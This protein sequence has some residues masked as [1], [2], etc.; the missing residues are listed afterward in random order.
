MES[1]T[2]TKNN[3]SVAI[4]SNA[5]NHHQF[6][7]CDS[8][9]KEDGVIFNFIATKPIAKERL[10]IG[11]LDL[12]NSREYIIRPYESEQ[13]KKRALEIAKSCDFVIYGSAPFEYIKDRIKNKKWTFIYSER[14]FKETRA[15]DLF[16][17]KTILACILRYSFVSH[18]KIRLLCSSAF[19][20]NDF[21][22]FGFKEIQTYKWGY[23]PPVSELDYKDIVN[24]KESLS[25]IWV[26]RMIH[27]KH[28]EL[29][30]E[31][32]DRINKNGVNFKMTIVGD[33]VML[34]KIKKL[35]D[36]YNVLD[37]V[38]FTGALSTE[39]TREEM[40]KAK[41]LITT[42]DHN[43]G[44]GAIVNEGM[45]S[46]CAVVASHL[47]GS[48]P[49]LIKDKETGFV[50][51]SL[52][53]EDLYTKVKT[54]LQD[55][56]LCRE[57]AKKGYESIADEFNGRVAAEKLAT[58]MKEYFNGNTDFAFENGICSIAK[59]LNNNWYKG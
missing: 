50:F 58:L 46:G 51:K 6:P 49:Y 16:N 41:I 9:Y 18:D 14:L 42:S 17:I 54:L 7:F 36:E 26:G 22:Y 12:N 57:V 27:W 40:E 43:E 24:G 11:F 44:W 1:T 13:E 31:L 2:D 45:A 37:K 30:I 34:P 29:A 53:C 23:F 5:M 35:A 10:D 3:I 52:D 21:K 33:G 8:M 38:K 47:M 55:D 4:I 39:R 19:A 25:L 56:V 28:P 15:K 20:S 32:A 48:V 59:H